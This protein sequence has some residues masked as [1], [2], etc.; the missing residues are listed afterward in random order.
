MPVQAIAIQ[1]GHKDV[2]SFPRLFR[3]A[4]GISP[5][6]TAAGFSSRQVCD[7]MR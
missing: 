5:D 2:T 7:R 1:V 6:P 4:G 3:Q